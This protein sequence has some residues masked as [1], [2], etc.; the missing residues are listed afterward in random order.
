MIFNFLSHMLD[1]FSLNVATRNKR[2]VIVVSKQICRMFF[3]NMH[4]I[5]N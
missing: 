5:L 4:T 3:I 2:K 1:Y